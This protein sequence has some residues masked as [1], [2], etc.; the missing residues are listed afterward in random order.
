MPS[1]TSKKCRYFAIYKKCKFGEFCKFSHE[2]IENQ[3]EKQITD[4]KKNLDDLRNQITVKE[5]EI[6]IKDDEIEVLNKHLQQRINNVEKKN[7]T[8][9]EHINKLKLDN[10]SMKAL[11]NTGMQKAETVEKKNEEMEKEIKNLKE[12]N[13]SKRESL[14]ST[15]IV[16]SMD[17]VSETEPNKCEKCDFVGKNPAGLKIHE[18]AKHKEKPLLQRFSRVGKD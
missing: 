12:E 4:I 8:L 1:K 6:K 15:M 9:E 2:A 5:R 14:K 11:V 17:V 3:E 10:E 13:E 16:G 18:T 7:E